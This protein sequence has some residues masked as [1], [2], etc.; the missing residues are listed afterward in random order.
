MRICCLLAGL[1]A[2]STGVSQKTQ[3]QGVLGRVYDGNDYSSYYLDPPY[4]FHPKRFWNVK[5]AHWLFHNHR[6]VFLDIKVSD[7]VSQ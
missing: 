6:Y 1:V 4:S 3:P 7:A 2:G 5:N